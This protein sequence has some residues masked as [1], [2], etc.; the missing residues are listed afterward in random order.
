MKPFKRLEEIRRE[1][2]SVVPTDKGNGPDPAMPNPPL[3]GRSE[4]RVTAVGGHRASEAAAPSR[5]PFPIEN[6]LRHPQAPGSPH[7]LCPRDAVHPECS[8]VRRR[9]TAP[10]RRRAR[11]ARTAGRSTGR[12][13]SGSPA[14]GR[15]AGFDPVLGLDQPLRPRRHEPVLPVSLTRGALRGRGT[16]EFPEARRRGPSC[17]WCRSGSSAASWRR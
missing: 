4:A 16:G 11:R 8:G 12:R 15:P 5:K 13:G 17:S 6:R 9:A 2:G 7:P 3:P 10:R 14:R 1:I